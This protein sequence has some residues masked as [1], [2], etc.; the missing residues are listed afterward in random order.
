MIKD[1]RHVF[2]DLDHTLWDFE[3]NSDASYLELFTK[4]GIELD[5][6]EFKRIYNPINA[7]YWK[8]YREQEVG[9]EELRYGRLKDSFDILGFN[10]S[11]ALID[12][13]AD[14]YILTLPKY[15]KL[16]D[17]SIE[18]LDYLK[19]KNYQ[20]HMITNGF[21]EVQWKKCVNS[22]ISNYFSAFITSESV[23]VQKPNPLV[24]KEALNRAGAMAAESIMIG[25][26]QEAD[27]QGALDSDMHAI[28]CNFDNQEN[29][30]NYLEVKKL[31]EIKRIL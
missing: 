10:A 5:F 2:F 21:K 23:G 22:G 31:E 13:L 27:V 24:F 3:S 25:D 26:N 30:G 9:K 19:E 1:V 12:E 14:D 8:K 4:R 15:N 11:D 16:F 29:T 7:M 17:G 18:L 20:L 28:F 6:D